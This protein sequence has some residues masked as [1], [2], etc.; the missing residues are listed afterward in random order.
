[1]KRLAI[2]L[3]LVSACGTDSLPAGGVCKQTSDCDSDLMCLDVAQ[4]SGTTCMVVGKSCSITCQDD[5][6]CASLG[7]NFRCFA[8]CGADKVCGMIAQ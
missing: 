4:F 5:A 1:M 2:V 7:S 3:L 6:G 8:G